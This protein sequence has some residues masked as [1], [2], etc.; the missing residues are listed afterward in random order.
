MVKAVRPQLLGDMSLEDISLLCGDGGRATVSAR[1]GRIYNG[2]IEERG[3]GKVKASFQ[4]SATAC[5]KY[6]EAA[7]GNNNRRKGM[8]K[9]A[10][11]SKSKTRNKKN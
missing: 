11:N 9:K 6:A 10:L 5:G 3:G 8:K 4:K 1:I 7:K 2:Y